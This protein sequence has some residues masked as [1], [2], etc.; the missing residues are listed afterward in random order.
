M[1]KNEYGTP[2]DRNGY[3]PSIIP[4]HDEYCCKLCGRN[5][6][7][8]PLNRHEVFGGAYRDKSKRLG[9]WVNLCHYNCHQGPDG[10]HANAEKANKL[11]A[12]A[13]RRAMRKYGWT[14]DEFR[15]EFGRN[16][17]ED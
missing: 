3:A 12:E 4:G 5:G 9:L 7:A 16:Y 1:K 6:T 14:V 10:V 8:D 11:K 13:Q 17:L 2:L 15:A